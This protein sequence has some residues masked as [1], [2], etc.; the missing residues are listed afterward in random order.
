[1]LLSRAKLSASLIQKR[2]AQPQL[3]YPFDEKAPHLHALASQSKAQKEQLKN[4]AWNYFCSLWVSAGEFTL[5]SDPIHQR[6]KHSRDY[7][8]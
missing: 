6:E 1:M 7:K 5:I 3:D 2:Q 4:L 8:C